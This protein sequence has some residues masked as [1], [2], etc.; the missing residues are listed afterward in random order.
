MDL[1]QDIR[2]AWGWTGIAPRH[3]VGDNA[4]GNLMIE[5]MDGRYWRL[6]PEDCHCTVVAA[7][8][9]ALDALARDPDF[10]Q[11]WAMDALVAEAQ[12]RCGPLEEGRRYCLRIPGVLGGAYG[13]DNLATAPWPEML[14]LSGD[15]A[16]QMQGL[17]D[18]SRVRLQVRD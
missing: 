6:C 12:E 15:I 9:A 14:R 8:R 5:D 13:G 1:L 7:D 16:R 11:D 4:F 2:D 17:P 3:I 10:V 18:G